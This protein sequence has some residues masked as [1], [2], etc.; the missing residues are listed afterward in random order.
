MVSAEGEQ[1]LEFWKIGEGVRECPW[2]QQPRIGGFPRE[3]RSAVLEVMK[4]EAIRYSDKK[5]TGEFGEN[6]VRQRWG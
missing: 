4:D 6:S 1:E 3:E 5:V 2:R